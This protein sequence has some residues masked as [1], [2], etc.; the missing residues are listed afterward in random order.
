MLFIFSTIK[1]QPT[2]SKTHLQPWVTSL[3]THRLAMVFGKRGSNYTINTR[4]KYKPTECYNVIEVVYYINQIELIISLIDICTFLITRA[5]LGGTK[6]RQTQA[7][8]L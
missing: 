3:T 5:G 2:P 4:V 7:Q 6:R 8:S 1:K